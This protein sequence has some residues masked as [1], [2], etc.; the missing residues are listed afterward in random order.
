MN[1]TATP[2]VSLATSVATET[3]RLDYLDAVRA[4]ALL[5]GIVFHAS[6]SFVPIYIGWAVMDI[7]TSPLVLMFMHVS[8]SFRMELFFLIAGFF[9]H[10]T[11][12]RKGLGSFL[13]SRVMRIVI[14][15][16]VGWFILRPL[17]VS[18]WIMGGA[19]LRGDV[20]IWAGLLGG[21]QS[22]STLPTGIFTGS[23]LWFLYYMVLVTGAALALRSLIKLFGSRQERWVVKG[24]EV[25]SSLG[26]SWYSAFALAVPTAVTLWYMNSWGV[27]T[28]DKTLVPHVPAFILYG[29]FFGFGWMLHRNA[30]LMRVFGRVTLVRVIIAVASIVASYMLSGFQGNPSHPHFVLAHFGYVTSYAV[31]IWALVFLTIGIFQKVCRRTNS[32]IRYVADASYWLYLVHLPIVIWLQVAVAELPFHWSLKLVGISVATILVSL[33]SYDLFVRSTF[34]GGVLNGRRRARVLLK[35]KQR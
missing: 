24:D 35:K 31:M 25:L 19:S 9:G 10:L 1:T 33:L 14:P 2:E 26:G 20:D 27:D 16:L 29:G 3:P 13:K 7:S 17:V 32:V 5:L 22:L 11:F 30:S 34:I 23:H 15:F 12:H 4:F 18:G 8:H 28:P 6:L 21:I